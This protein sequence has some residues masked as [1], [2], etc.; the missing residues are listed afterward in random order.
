VLRLFAA[1]TLLFINLYACKGGY[2]SCKLKIHD[3]YA[4]TNSQT[5]IPVTKHKRVVFSRTKPTAKILKHD[6]FLS[7]YLVED[8]K[9]F[10]YPFQMLTSTV[11][12]VACVD[13]KRAVEGH[14]EKH[15]IGLNEFAIFDQKVSS[16]ALLLTSCCSLE[17]IVTP[18]GIIEKEYI[19]RFLKIKKVSYSDIGIRV[20][21]ENSKVFVKAINPFM[22]G[23]NF[24]VGD[25]VLKFDN[26]QVSNAAELMQWILFSEIGSMHKV[27]I[28]RNDKYTTLNVQSKRRKGGGYLSDTFLEFLGLSFDKHL[29]II[30]IESK[31]KKYGLKLGD[32]LLGVNHKKIT[33]QEEI[34]KMISQSKKATDLLFERHAF[35]FFVKVKSL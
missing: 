11:M 3:S 20:K 9:G 16:P 32:K 31:A 12:G 33:T 25:Q 8:K 13:R 1:F 28:K 15:Q 22:D 5:N 18:E 4:L 26:K 27:E 10:P 21:E 23:N 30:K 19:E 35:Q 34:I 17:G 24:L 2:N 7:L 29:K 14:I 6:P